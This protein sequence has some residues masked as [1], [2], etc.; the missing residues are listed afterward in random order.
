M[1]S[2][3]ILVSETCFQNTKTAFKNQQAS[4]QGLKTQMGQL[5]RL[6]SERPQS[7]LPSNTE[8]NLREHL[9]AISTQDK[10]GF[11]EPEP[12]LTQETV[13]SKGELTLRRD[14][15]ITLQ[16]HNSGITSN[17]E[18][19]GPHHSTKPNNMVQ[20]ILQKMSLNEAHES[21]SSNNRE[22]VHEDQRLQ[23]EERDEWR[24]HKP[25]TPDKPKLCQN[26][27]DTSPNQLKVGDKVRC[28]RSAHCHYYT[29]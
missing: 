9:N 7:I 15:M 6:I 8:P 20:P 25:R 21:F 16:A 29:E 1:L 5:S 12:E 26:K 24:M 28:R 2:K 17:I 3:F 27:P 14:E 19:Y 4:I 23:I 11:I 10:E 13:V 18:G 22:P